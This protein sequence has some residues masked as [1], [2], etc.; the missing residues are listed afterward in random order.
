[1]TLGERLTQL[2][3]QRGLSQEALAKAAGVSRQSVSKWENNVSVPE[4]DQLIRLSTLLEISLDEL[5]TGMPPR[6]VSASEPY[7]AAG[8]TPED[9]RLHR[10]TVIGVIL[11]ALSTI[12]TV[13]MSEL[14][15]L[16]ALPALLGLLCLTVKRRIGLVTGWAIWLY[17]YAYATLFTSVEMR[18][19]FSPDY[20]RT[21]ALLSPL[22]GWV[23]LAAL[24]GLLWRTRRRPLCLPALWSIWGIVLIFSGAYHSSRFHW[25]FSRSIRYWDTPMGA[26]LLLGFWTA[27]LWLLR[28]SFRARNAK[29]LEFTNNKR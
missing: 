24:A 20:Y 27:F 2:R 13:C 17:S 10:Q 15:L 3:N 5:A 23:Q 6:T 7:P 29:R 16:A 25:Y 26:L 18:L 1:M 4:L 28:A 19:L 11:L 22:L 14:V 21:C 9:L 12:L 8:I